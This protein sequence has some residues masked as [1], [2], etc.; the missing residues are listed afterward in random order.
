MTGKSH[1]AIGT[2][3]GIAITIYGLRNGINAAPLAL[4]SAPLA[5]LLPDVDHGSSKLGQGRQQVAKIA[6]AVAGLALIVAAWYYSAYIV[7]NYTTLVTM[8]LGVVGPVAV[9]I[10]IGQTRWAK[11]LIG[12]ASKHRGI[13][14]TL[15]IPACLIFVVWF[16][17]EPYFRILLFGLIAGYLSHIIADCLT[18][19]G[20]P[21]L[22]PITTKTIN[23]TNITTGSSGEKICMA[24]MITVIIGASLIL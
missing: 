14:H 13:T 6:I 21:I 7:A 19:K 5:S 1:K 23:L 9:I 3:V 8:A 22:F 15:V 4:V 16:V 20:C 11:N 17:H 10:F 24:V 12:F 2:A 18:K